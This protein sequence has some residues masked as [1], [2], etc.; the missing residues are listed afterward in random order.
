MISR[1]PIRT[2]FNPTVRQATLDSHKGPWPCRRRFPSRATDRFLYRSC[3]DQDLRALWA[4]FPSVDEIT[5]YQMIPAHEVPAPYHGLLV[6]QRHMTPSLEAFHGGQV[7]VHV[8]ASRSWASGY[9]RKILLAMQAS[10]RV[11]EFSIVRVYLRHCRSAVRDEILA[12]R[13]PLGRILAQHRVPR[14]I[15]PTAFVRFLPGPRLVQRFGLEGPRPLYGRVGRIFCEER[16]MLELLE[17]VAA[18]E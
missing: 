7:G 11:V 5:G 9:A 16:P 17:I 13:T 4:L 15:E 3:S 8:L 10:G 12:E 2:L 6:H 14:R 1:P 18:E